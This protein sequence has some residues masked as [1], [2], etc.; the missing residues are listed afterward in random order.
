MIVA[1][2]ELDRSREGYC[3]DSV[4][5]VQGDPGTGQAR[6]EV[7]LQGSPS[8]AAVAVAVGR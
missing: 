5:G 2:E 7:V 6:E 1:S 4:R 8:Q 3:E